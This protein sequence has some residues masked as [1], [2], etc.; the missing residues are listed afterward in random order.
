MC[1]VVIAVGDR[2]CIQCLQHYSISA[3]FILL[4]FLRRSYCVSW[5]TGSLLSFCFSVADFMFLTV[6]EFVN[7]G[8]KMPSMT[9]AT[10]QVEDHRI[11]NDDE[12]LTSLGYQPGTIFVMLSIYSRSM[13]KSVRRAQKIV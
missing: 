6:Y 9:M 1:Y 7:Q 3:G 5:I 12:K 2:P 11:A 13:L 8:K 10:R 4:V